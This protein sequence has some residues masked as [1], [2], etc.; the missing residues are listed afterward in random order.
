VITVI[1]PT[2]N[3]AELLAAALASLQQQTFSRKNFEVLVIDNG[4]ID[5]TTVVTQKYSELLGNVRYFYES[6]LGLHV[7][8]HRGMLEAKND[9][10]VF[11]DDDIEAFPTWLESI[12]EAFNDP[13]V[14]MVGGNNLPMFLKPPPRWLKKLWNR[15]IRRNTRILSALSILEVDVSTCDFSPYYV[16]GCNLSITKQVLL[17]AGGFHPDGVPKELIRFRGDGETHVS[18]FVLES[19]KRCVFHPGAS[20]Y[21][22]VT[23]ERMTFEYFHQRGFNQGVSDSYTELRNQDDKTEKVRY[24]ILCRI[25]SWCRCKL[26]TMILM[27]S[28]AHR[29]LNELHRGHKEG[30]AYHQQMYQDDEAVR[31]WVH[32]K[33]YY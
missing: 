6:E 25:A 22:K 31:A 21:H 19:G 17:D 33:K 2:R 30:Y 18:R 13:D 3:R 15:P 11:A 9:I 32:K 7:G 1:I 16:W 26:E 24:S 10:L 12:Q 14:V 8:R 29:A 20:V 5:N 28:E 27:S 23:P 4:S